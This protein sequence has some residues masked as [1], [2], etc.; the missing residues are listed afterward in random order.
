MREIRVHHEPIVA[1]RAV[2]CRR[3]SLAPW[4][5][6]EADPIQLVVV[7]GTRCGLLLAD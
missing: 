5:A 3:A 2:L 7:V 4:R 6:A 1:V